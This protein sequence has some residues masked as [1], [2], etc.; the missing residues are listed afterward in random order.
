MPQ[1]KN[2]AGIKRNQMCAFGMQR[3]CV[4][5]SSSLTH[6]N[7]TVREFCQLPLRLLNQAQQMVPGCA[8]RVPWR[9]PCAGLA[10]ALRGRAAGAGGGREGAAA[11]AAAESCQSAPDLLFICVIG[12]VCRQLL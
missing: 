10:R 2:R 5:N 9:G 4:T 8:A 7:P 3:F 11:G 12:G 6:I 1:K